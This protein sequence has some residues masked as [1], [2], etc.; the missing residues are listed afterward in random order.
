MRDGRLSLLG[1]LEAEGLIYEDQAAGLAVEAERV[2]LS[3]MPWSFMKEG[4]FRIDDCEVKKAN[5]RILLEGGPDGASS[6][7]PAVRTKSQMTILPLAVMRAR[8]E[9]VTF[10]IET[11]DRSITGKMGAAIDNLGPARTGFVDLKTNFTVVHAG[12]PALLS[13]ALELAF[14]VAAGPSGMPITWKGTNQ[15]L[16]RNG[17]EGAIEQADADTM[18]FDQTLE[19]EWQASQSLRLFSTIT[20]HKQGT[21]LGSAAVTAAINTA[22]HP[23]MTDLTLTVTDLAPDTMNL[24]WRPAAARLSGGRFDAGIEARL[25]GTHTSVRGT[26]TGSRCSFVWTI[27]R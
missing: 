21:P 1:G 4:V 7:T 25:G 26:I 9:D 14:S 12:E 10:M 6:H 3:A 17:G 5:L 27:V 20:G 2:A 24:L 8:F 15:A 18:V 16:L 23:V 11:D 19:G 22:E 13:A